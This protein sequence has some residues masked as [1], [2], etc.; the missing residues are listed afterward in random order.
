VPE[1]H[2]RRGPR[3]FRSPAQR[4]RIQAKRLGEVIELR[5]GNPGLACLQPL[6]RRY[7][8]FDTI[9][10]IRQR[11]SSPTPDTSDHRTDLGEHACRLPRG[12]YT[13]LSRKSSLGEASESARLE[14]MLRRATEQVKRAQCDLEGWARSAK[15]F[16][17][18]RRFLR[19]VDALRDIKQTLA[20]IQDGFGLSAAGRA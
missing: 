2:G 13:G 5:R 12:R 6:Q 11:G 8:A 16:E 14:Q 18:Y 4:P 17:E 7:V 20:A 9:G 19:H 10:E 1:K 3:T 15:Y